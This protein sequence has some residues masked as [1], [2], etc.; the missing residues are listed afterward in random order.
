MLFSSS[1]FFIAGAL[2]LG[3]IKMHYAWIT[4]LVLEIAVQNVM[5]YAVVMGYSLKSYDGKID[6]MLRFLSLIIGPA[7][8]IFVASD[9]LMSG[10]K[11]IYWSFRQ[12]KYFRR[13]SKKQWEKFLEKDK[14]EERQMQEEFAYW[15]GGKT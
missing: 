6:T 4:F 13:R 5:G 2:L 7:V 1:P 11:K 8:L 3:I 10:E 14:V 9:I 15:E 12:P